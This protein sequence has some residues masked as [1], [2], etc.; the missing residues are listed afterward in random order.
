MVPSH[1]CGDSGLSAAYPFKYRTSAAV[2]ESPAATAVRSQ[3]NHS[4]SFMFCPC[5]TN[6]HMPLF[7]QTALDPS[8]IRWRGVIDILAYFK[9]SPISCIAV[10]NG[11]PVCSV[12]LAPE[13]IRRSFNLRR[14]SRIQI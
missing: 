5:R 14:K 11:R 4:T 12:Q 6:G 1:L 13:N 8:K 10:K 9:S 2:W 7:F 3:S